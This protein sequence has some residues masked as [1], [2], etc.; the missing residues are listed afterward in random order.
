MPR[1]CPAITSS[2]LTRSPSSIDSESIVY[3]SNVNYGL[4]RETRKQIARHSTRSIVST[5]ETRRVSGGRIK[6]NFAINLGK[7]R[8]SLGVALY[9]ES[10][11]AR[12]GDGKR[13]RG[14]ENERER[15]G[16]SDSGG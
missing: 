13:N 3:S 11:S 12:R 7:T 4:Y 9:K 16:E 5:E 6:V 1:N 14:S 15:W 10:R 8:S 2:K